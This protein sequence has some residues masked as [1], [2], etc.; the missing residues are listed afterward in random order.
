MHNLCLSYAPNFLVIYW[1][2]S[3]SP[4]DVAAC[5]TQRFQVFTLTPKSNLSNF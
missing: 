3:E 1:V 5:E 2:Q 4:Q